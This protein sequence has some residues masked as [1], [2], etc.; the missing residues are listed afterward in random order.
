MTPENKLFSKIPYKYLWRFMWFAAFAGIFLLIGLFIYVARTKMPDTKELENPKFEQSSI[1]YAEDMVELD[2]YFQSNRQWVKYDDLSQNLVDALIATEDLRFFKHSGIDARGTARA[3][4]FVGSRGGASTITQQLAKQFFTERRS[5]NFMKRVWQKMKEWVIAVEFERRY[6][7]EEILAMFLNK[8]DFRYQANGIGA[9]ANIY[10]GKEQN[11]LSVN[12]AALLVGMLKN[13]VI[14]DPVKYLERAQS[15]RNVVLSQMRKYQFITQGEYE[16]HKA[17]PIDMSS[18]NRGETFDG[19]APHFMVEL[20]KYIKDVFE[21]NDIRKPGGE[22]YDLDTDGLKIFTTIDSRF[23]KHA[24]EAAHNQIKILQNRFDQVW[25]TRDPWTYIDPS[26]NLTKEQIEVQRRIRNNKLTQ[27]IE[28]TDLYTKLRFKYLNGPIKDIATKIPDSRLLNGDIKRLLAAEDDS[29]YLT[30]QLN[31]NYITKTQKKTYEKILE[32]PEWKELKIA[33]TQ[34]KEEVKH[35]FNNAKATK[36]YSYEGV[37][38]VVM[39]PIDSIKHMAGFLQIG[40]MSL[41]PKTGYV[42]TWIGG[43]NFDFWKYDKVTSSRQVGSTFKPFL[44]TAAINNGV[45]PCFKVRDMQYV[46]SANEE[47][48]K[49]IKTW[50]PQN[51]RG[52]FSDEEITLKEALKLSL[53]SA[54]IYLVKMLESVS[55]II[56]VAENMGITKDKIDNVPSI[57]LGAPSLSVYEMCRAY[58][59]YANDGISAKPVFLKR[60]EYN[61]V[62][63]YEEQPQQ[64]RALAPNV[65]YAMVDL[66]KHASSAVTY[67]L[68]SEF[69][70]KT[71][72]TNSHVDGWF[73]GITPDLVTGTWVGGEDSWIR[74]LTLDDG[75]G[76]RMARPFFLDYMERIENDPDIQFN[77]ESAFKVPLDI[78]IELDCSAYEQFE[79]PTIDTTLSDEIEMIE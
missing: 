63:I 60:I 59:T 37:K 38:D 39:S 48:F 16:K 77:T 71:G 26:E 41:D 30:S 55:P 72:T 10:F 65:N 24:V 27:L 40:T 19:L 18:F 25:R 61:G 51:S 29:K 74:F 46:I 2:R 1:V 7:K 28:S 76:S 70:G 23:Q 69:G 5:K 52:K 66:L 43:T 12:E 11:D 79:K 20:K 78:G 42:K 49:L 4:A 8:F 32:L 9:A 57:V 62:T 50:A 36:V 22:D 56:E 17:N 75:Q 73:M 34:L 13:P 15:R 44:Y 35:Q 64:H 31:I 67:R 53:N 3:V 68:K 54:S 47:P 14:Y 21:K 58:T 45:S 6:T 33:W